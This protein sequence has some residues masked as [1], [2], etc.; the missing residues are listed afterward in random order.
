MR[1]Y[2]T[3]KTMHEMLFH[4]FMIFVNYQVVQYLGKVRAVSR[5]PATPKIEF[6]VILLD[7][8]AENDHVMS[9]RDIRYASACDSK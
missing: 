1:K 8:T 9:Q 7:G 5:A 2:G 3:N 4:I 6:F